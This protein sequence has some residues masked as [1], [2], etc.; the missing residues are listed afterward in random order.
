MSVPLCSSISILP[1]SWVSTAVTSSCSLYILSLPLHFTAIAIY[2]RLFWII[3]LALLCQGY[4]P[5]YHLQIRL[6]EEKTPLKVN[7]L[8]RDPDLKFKLDLL[9]LERYIKKVTILLKKLNEGW[10]SQLYTQLLQLRKESQKKKFRLVRDSSPWSLQY[11]CNA[12]PI[13]L[14]SQQGADR[15]IGSL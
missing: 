7:H 6:A 11:Q 15:W 9:L 3:I 5:V 4:T 14:T 13:K 8:L 10:S 2:C 1:L 12:L